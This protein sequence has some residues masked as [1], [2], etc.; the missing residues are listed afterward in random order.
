[1]MQVGVMWMGMTQRRM[2]VPMRMRFADRAV[3]RMPV[4]CVVSM[5]VLVFERLVPMLV[6]MPL[7]EMHPQPKPHQETG[8]RKARCY[9]LVQEADRQ[10]RPDKRRER[11]ISAGA[12][13]PEMTQRPHEEHEANPYPGEADDGRSDGDA[14]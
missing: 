7:G 8:E 14:R 9:G 11:K 1:M 4:V 6:L 12:G 13:R 10:H 3:M 5:A 2:A